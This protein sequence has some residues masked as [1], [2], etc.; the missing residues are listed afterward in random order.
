MKLRL[1]SVL[2]VTLGLACPTVAQVITPL[3]LNDPKLQRLQQ[4]NFRTL[5]DMGGEIQRYKVPYPF[6]LSRVLDVDLSKMGTAQES[7]EGCILGGFLE[8]DDFSPSGRPNIRFR[9]K[10]AEFAAL[11]W[12]WHAAG[13]REE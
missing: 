11:L 3:E 9:R 4:K 10:W 1:V 7:D 2:L 8:N 6:Y 5:I 13:G 12:K